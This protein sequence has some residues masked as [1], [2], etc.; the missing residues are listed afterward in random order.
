MLTTFP[1]HA[2][3]SW[4]A[5]MDAELAE[6]DAITSSSSAQM[7]KGGAEPTLM[8]SWEVGMDEELDQRLKSPQ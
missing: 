2:S 4:V 6:F 1:S 5:E 8:E 3:A 7:Q